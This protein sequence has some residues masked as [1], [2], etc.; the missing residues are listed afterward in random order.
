[1]IYGFKNRK[2]FS[3]FEFFMLARMFVEIYH[4]WTLEF[5][6]SSNLQPKVSKFYD[7]IIE[8]LRYWLDFGH[9]RRNPVIWISKSLPKTR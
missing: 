9:R 6:G 3:E 5:V 2:T 7:P 1:M 8:I 4:C